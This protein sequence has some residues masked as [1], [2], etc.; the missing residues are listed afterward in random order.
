MF[1]SVKAYGLLILLQS[2]FNGFGDVLSKFAY[3]VMPVFS[4]LSI[5]YCIGFSVMLL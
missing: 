1:K 5:R 2:L 4:L 3:G